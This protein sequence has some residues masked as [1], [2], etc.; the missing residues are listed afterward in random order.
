MVLMIMYAENLIYKL[1]LAGYPIAIYNRTVPAL[2][3]ELLSVYIASSRAEVHVFD[4][5]V[6]EVGS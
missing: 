1:Q 3:R 5:T 4:R 6:Q 2:L